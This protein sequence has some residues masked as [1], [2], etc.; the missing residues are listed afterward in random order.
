LGGTGEGVRGHAIGAL[1]NRTFISIM[2]GT[3]KHS[4]SVFSAIIS[5][6]DEIGFVMIEVLLCRRIPRL[7]GLY[8]NVRVGRAVI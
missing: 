1:I 8:V 6:V 3:A 7:S 2:K 5:I 4:L